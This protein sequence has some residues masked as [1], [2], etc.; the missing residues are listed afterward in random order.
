MRSMQSP[1]SLL[2]SEGIRSS[3]IVTFG[4]VFGTALSAIALIIISRFLGPSEFG[5]FSA[6]FSVMMIM[7]RLG[8]FGLNLALQR[9]LARSE[10]PLRDTSVTNIFYI[11]IFL[12]VSFIFIFTSASQILDTRLLHF[13]SR[14]LVIAALISA[15]GVVFYE[16]IGVVV[17]A[18]HKFSHYAL[19]VIFQAI[20]K[21]VT[22]LALIRTSLLTPINAIIL[23]GLA[24]LASGLLVSRLAGVKI[25][26]ISRL[27]SAI[28]DSSGILKVAKWTSVAM[29][30]A[31]I[32]D[33]L[34]VL[35]IQYFL[36]PF[37]TGLFSAA[38]RI[39]TFFSLVGISVGSVLNIRVAKYHD[40][41]NLD[42]Y[43][44]KSVKYS[45]AIGALLLMLIPF[46]PLM[47]NLTAGPDYAL[48]SNTLDFLFVATAILAA[49][50]PYV[51]LFFVFDRPQYFA[52]SGTISTLLLL[53][54][55]LLMIPSL[56]TMGASYARIITR[57]GVLIFTILYAIK[58]Y[59]EH[60]STNE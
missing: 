58:S 45:L 9:Y 30:S 24:P 7:V 13:D 54:S 51:A 21:I 15:L 32:A 20:G 31:A 44:R 59:K 49:T 36:T 4:N 60:F 22:V 52:L 18:A 19:T 41:E 57:V 16:F 46:S 6:A 1:K 14:S 40:K 33:N 11:K 47:I 26:Q 48:A 23:Y 3:A 43:I 50:S 56:G 27:T 5:I 39:S 17:Q 25:K 28:K 8:D 34:D 55:D 10:N 35:I 29:I 53:S 2:K 37:D 38:L 42:K 12:S